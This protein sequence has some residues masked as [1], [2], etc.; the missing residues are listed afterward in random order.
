MIHKIISEIEKEITNEIAQIQESL[1]DGICQDYSHY[2]HL[3]GSIDGLNKSKMVI[4]NIYKKMID[5]D[6][7][8]DD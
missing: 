1:G 2:K 3:T 5:G 7:D 4:K 6:E 8:A